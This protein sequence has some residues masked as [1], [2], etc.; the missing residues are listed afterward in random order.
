MRT[1]ESRT[2]CALMK[3]SICIV[4]YNS[5]HLLSA[6]LNSIAAFPPSSHYEI[7]VVD[8]DSADGSALP[9]SSV[10][11]I[12]LIR[13]SSNAGFARGNNQ[14]FARAHGEYLLLLNA[15]T[16][17]EPEALDRLIAFAEAH[18]RAGLVSAKLLDPDGTYQAGFNVRRLPTLATAIAQL[19][20]LDE[21]WP[22]NPLTRRYLAA[23][24][25]PEQ[26]QQVEQ[27]AAS[28]LLYRRT[29]YAQV[30]GLDERFPNWYNDVDLC[31]RVRAAGWE[32]WYY[33]GARVTHHGGMGAASRAAMGVVLE[34]YRSQRRYY[35]KHFGAA[36]YRIVSGFVVLG[37]VL[38]LVALSLRPR[39]AA[40]V[41]TR[42]QRP[43]PDTMR[44]AFRAVLRDTVRTWR[45]L[46]QRDT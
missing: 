39:L 36:G 29:T 11:G 28:A 19:T 9:A 45:S 37:M 46:P 43:A 18:P 30:G 23:D 35:Y 20:L 12:T 4:N 44:D 24:M 3:L 10:P 31:H 8:N 15:D 32:V 27:P 41:S 25:D 26:P 14:A 17:L 13:N 2:A 7:L 6:C 21:A 22:H 33:P 42:A 1:K 34:N 5:G 38:R 16:E 40:R